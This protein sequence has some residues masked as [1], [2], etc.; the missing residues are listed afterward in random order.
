MLKTRGDVF[1]LSDEG[2]EMAMNRQLNEYVEE[3][4]LKLSS[5]GGEGQNRMVVVPFET[6]K[7][8]PR[9]FEWAVSTAEATL[10][11]LVFLCVRPTEG[12]MDA[13]KEGEH[14]FSDLK[15]LQAQIQNCAV[16]VSIETVA[17]STARLVLDYVDETHADIIVIPGNP[18]D[19]KVR[20]TA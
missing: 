16:P 6:L 1:V 2:S 11:E 7:L 4:P 9:T 19:A 10:A 14:L 5:E 8:S 20:A 15:G 12:S 3:R 18:V 17:G 13:A